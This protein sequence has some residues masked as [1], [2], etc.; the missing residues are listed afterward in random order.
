M[1]QAIRAVI[2]SIWA[3]TLVGAT[4][5]TPAPSIGAEQTE[6]LSASVAAPLK[7]AQEAIHRK[8]WGKAIEA[9]DKTND[10]A[11]KSAKEQYAINELLAYVLYQ[12]KSYDQAAKIYE[13]QLESGL[14][15]AEQRGQRA[16]AVAEMFFRVGNYPKTIKWAKVYLESHPEQSEVGALLGESYFAIKDYKLAAATMTR[17]V[18]DA[19]RAK[20]TPKQSWLRIID[21]S[22]YQLSDSAGRERALT[23]L[24]RYYHSTDDWNALLRDYSHDVRDDEIAAGYR[25]LKFDLGMLTSVDDYEELVFDALDAGVPSEAL[26][27]I[28]RGNKLG[29]FSGPD[30]LP[31]KYERLRRAVQ[32]QTGEAR[33]FMRL[34]AAIPLTATTAHDDIRAGQI[35]LSNGKYAEAIAALKHG[36]DKSAAA[37]ADEATINLGIAYLKQGN[38]DAA[39]QTFHSIDAHSKWTDLATLWSLRDESA[40]RT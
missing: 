34:Y 27:A 21:N 30:V 19:E 2:A 5:F 6:L 17:V 32:K 25:F 23:K 26:K 8:N 38:R 15:P 24:V 39:V 4:L 36:I 14:M 9:I 33:D 40:I 29:L 16:K 3:L 11:N 13:Q 35:Y 1:H 31:G 12:Q 20:K 7:A 18:A 10:I 22:Y 37:D 28:E